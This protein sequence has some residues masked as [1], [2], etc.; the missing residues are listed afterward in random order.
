MQKKVRKYLTTLVVLLIV[1]AAAAWFIRYW[2]TPEPLIYV[3][4]PVEKRDIQQTVSSTGVLNAYKQVDVGAQVSGQLQSLKVSLGDEVKK[5]QLLAVID[6]SVKENDLKD[7]ESQLKN[8]E[9]QKH[10]KYVEIF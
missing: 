4:V 3:T 9:A 6:P 10:S 8:V 7:A 2:M 1:A 5:G